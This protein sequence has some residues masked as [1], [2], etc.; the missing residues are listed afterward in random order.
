MHASDCD[1]AILNGRVIDPETRFDDV[2][3]VCVKDGKIA[4]ITEEDIQ[5]DEVIDASGHVVAPG[6][7]D[8]QTHSAGSLWGVKVGLRD[9]VTTP[10][11]FEIG[12]INVA[13]WYAEREGKWPVNIGTVAAHELHRMR[14][15][16]KMPLPDPVDVWKLAEL[17]AQSYKEN[18]VPDWQETLASLDQLNA[19][20]AG[21][22]EELRAG[23]LGIGSTM[24]YM[25]KSVTTFEMFQVQKVAANFSRVFASHVRH[26]GNTT[27]PSEGTL[28]GLEQIA[29]SAALK[30]P[31]L[32]SHN[33]NF[34]WWEIEE[35][36]Q[37]LRKQGYNF[38]SEYYPYTSGSTTIGAAFL[39]PDSIELAGT[40]YERMLNP[41]T[42]KFMN[43]KEYEQIVAKDPGF[44]I[45]AFIDSRK[46]W[47]PLW[48]KTPHMTVASDAMP[49]VDV[50]GNYLKGDDP[51]EKFNG[52][53]RTVGTHA[54]V[55]RLAREHKVPL[56][57]TLS[58]LSYWSAK[59]LGDAGIEAMKVR[60]RM[61]EG[62][63]A[64]I[65]IFDPK[66][67]TDNSTY[68]EGENGL[69]STG[70][71]YVLVYGQI[72]VK[73]SKVL[74]GVY[75]GKPIRYPV[76]DKGRFVPLEKGTYLE[77]LLGRKSIDVGDE[78]MSPDPK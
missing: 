77:S 64:D 76:A 51:Y 57:H 50:E 16:D 58:Q 7:I 46:P 70:I 61:Q 41:Q 14:V 75:P 4:R 2:R 21:L 68:K 32:L 60:G 48:L 35:R 39:E 11:D 53:P 72:V 22:D 10:L 73:D 1:I 78:T 29:N 65:T 49:P 42:G 40:S 31:S 20:L 52:H 13:A 37:L 25:S 18:N 71:P 69:P 6:F 44:I 26:L 9:G 8:T 30:Q 27:P 47:L 34:G 38:W 24:G 67:V 43:K 15:M 55:L 28:G 17:R 56:L 66:T 63:V 74:D 54:K 5:S 19:I 62:M 3:N 23:A 12:A 59:H 33:N 45:V 36:L